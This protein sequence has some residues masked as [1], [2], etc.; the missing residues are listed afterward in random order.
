MQAAFESN[1]GNLTKRVLHYCKEDSRGPATGPAAEILGPT[2]AD[3]TAAMTSLAS[4]LPALCPGFVIAARN[5]IEAPGSSDPNAWTPASPDCD[6]ETLVE[7]CQFNSTLVSA[8][9]HGELSAGVWPLV[10]TEPGALT[11]FCTSSA[12]V[13]A[14][15]SC[16]GDEIVYK[17]TEFCD[18][19]SHLP[20]PCRDPMAYTGHLHSYDTAARLG[21]VWDGLAPGVL[22]AAD[23]FCPD[24]TRRDTAG[25][26]ECYALA[27]V[28]RKECLQVVANGCCYAGVLGAGDERCAEVAASGNL[29]LHYHVQAEEARNI[30]R[31]VLERELQPEDAAVQL[32]SLKV[33]NLKGRTPVTLGELVML[34]S[35]L[36]D[37][38]LACEAAQVA[39]VCADALECHND[40]WDSSL[41]TSMQDAL[42]GE[43]S[44]ECSNV[45]CRA[46]T[47]DACMPLPLVE[48][49]SL[50]AGLDGNE[51]ALE[52]LPTYLLVS[53]LLE[54]GAE[55]LVADGEFGGEGAPESQDMQ[56]AIRIVFEEGVCSDGCMVALSR[57]PVGDLTDT[58]SKMT[59]HCGVLDRTATSAPADKDHPNHVAEDEP[60]SWP[61]ASN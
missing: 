44:L 46:A 21:F 18:C 27:I 57:C 22:S 4:V 35:P 26:G 2:G 7:E 24:T 49:L 19:M 9:E 61:C 60:V 40:V 59:E 39:G 32:Q 13:S 37:D 12:C 54:Q 23:S 58:V 45:T 48:L 55:D 30:T 17:Q 20:E 29:T 36:Q 10:T 28:E 41:G 53:L 1:G 56:E 51:L 52:D 38:A 34:T 14:A 47:L 42:A 50:L 6:M 5:T 3:D 15:Q 16:L 11:K 43:A 33:G 25:M 31:R 8:I